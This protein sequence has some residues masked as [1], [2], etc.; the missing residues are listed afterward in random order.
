M[1]PTKRISAIDALDHDFFW[2]EPLPS[3]PEHLPKYPPSHE[4]TAKKRRQ[5]AQQQGAAHGAPQQQ[6]GAHFPPGAQGAGAQH[7]HMYGQPAHGQGYYPPVYGQQHWRGP[8]HQPFPGGGEPAAKRY[9]D[10]AGG[11]NQPRAGGPQ[12]MGMPRQQ[13]PPYRGGQMMPQ[14]GRGHPPPHHQNKGPGDNG[15]V[16]YQK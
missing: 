15:R 8:V 13:P 14:G 16:P 2:T 5:A 3:K 6:P 1:D 10:E 4:F 11:Y 9:R 7:G 12:H